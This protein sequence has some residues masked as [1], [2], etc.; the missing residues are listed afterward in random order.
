MSL[1]NFK[2]ALTRRHFLRTC[3]TGL[4]SLWLAEQLSARTIDGQSHF[5]G[6]AK[7]VI[8]LHMAGS[9]S[10]LELFDHKPKLNELNGKPCPN[11][12]LEGKRFAFIRGVPELLG[13]VH[14]FHQEKKTGFWVSNQ[15]PHLEEVFDRLCFVRSM[16][17]DQFNHAPAQL[18]MHTGSSNFGG[19]SM[20][21]WLTYGLGS[22]T[23]NLPGYIVLLSG[24]RMVDAGKSVWGS[25]FLP[26]IYQGVQCRSSGEPVLYLNNPSEIDSQ[27]RQ[28]I[29]DAIAAIN[30]ETFEQI[31]DPEIET[32]IKQYELAFRMQTTANEAFDLSQETSD[33]HAAYGTEPGKE[34]FANNCLL[35]RRLVERGVRFV[36][37][38]DWG[39]DSHG[40][41]ETEALESGFVRKCQSVDRPCAA[42][43]KDL[44]SRGLLEDTLVV[45]GGEFGR[46]PMRENRGGVNNPFIGRDHNP[47][48]F[49]MWIAGGGIKPGFEFG[50]TDEIGYDVS[51]NPVSVHD[52]HATLLQLLGFDH[53]R[54]SFPAPGGVPQRLTTITKP[55]KVVQALLA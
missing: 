32:R 11:S 25:G 28:Q 27:A 37:L 33:I 36:Q 3:T 49:T 10:S 17:T 54:F 1:L 12:L 8:W 20:G 43:I 18:L 34:S 14:P 40:G 24:G 6:K 29:V 38:F 30:K 4:G 35:A 19:A 45:W 5:P 2:L 26:S 22:E 15:L 16:K 23:T 39:W 46:T 55:A 9:P 31:G 44:E 53:L 47:N 7:R 48:A 13:G 50:T 51:E 21:S 41:A 52:L 42:L